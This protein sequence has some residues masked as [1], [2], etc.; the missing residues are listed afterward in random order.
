MKRQELRLCVCA[1][2]VSVAPLTSGACPERLLGAPLGAS[3]CFNVAVLG[4]F[5][6]TKCPTVGPPSSVPGAEGPQKASEG[7]K[8]VRTDPRRR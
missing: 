3:P 2:C 6:V 8:M 7:V 5:L 4:P 1:L